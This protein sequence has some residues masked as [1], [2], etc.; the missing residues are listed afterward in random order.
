MNS[1]VP[2]EE[3]LEKVKNLPAGKPFVMV[4][5]LKFK[6]HSDGD[7]N[8]TGEQAYNRYMRKTARILSN[9][10]GQVIYMGNSQEFLIAADGD[11]WDRV[12]LVKYPE[13]AAFLN[14][15]S[16]PEY[17]KVHGDREAGLERTALFATHSL[18][19]D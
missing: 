19:G 15:V 8:K 4:N 5:L 11:R 6:E 14:M 13:P 9:A 1:V 2:M 18:L 10:G 17:Q 7:P 16:S 3:D 12:L